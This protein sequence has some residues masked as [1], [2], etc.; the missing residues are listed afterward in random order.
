MRG[1]GD[2]LRYDSAI[3]IIRVACK[4]SEIKELETHEQAKEYFQHDVA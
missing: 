1:N 3:F 2:F 4:D